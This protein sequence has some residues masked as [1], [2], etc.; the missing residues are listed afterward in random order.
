MK[1]KLTNKGKS[2]IGE[3]LNNYNALREAIDNEM[4]YKVKVDEKKKTLSKFKIT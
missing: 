3:S 4:Q 1:N 2:K